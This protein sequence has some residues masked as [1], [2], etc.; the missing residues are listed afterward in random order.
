MASSRFRSHLAL[1]AGL[2]AASLALPARADESEGE[3]LFQE[4]RALMLAERFAEAC[5]K[6]EQSQ[7]LEPHGGTLL[8][9]AA[10]HE[11]VGRVATAWAEFHEALAAARA[12]GHAARQ[13]LAEERIAVL[14]PRLPWLTINVAADLAGEEVRLTFDGGEIGRIAWGKDMPIDPGEHLIVATAPGHVEVQRRIT[15]RESEHE[16]VELSGLAPG[17]PTPVS[18][19]PATP[20]D[21]PPAATPPRPLKRWVFEAG[22]F[23]AFLTGNMDPAGLDADPSTVAVRGGAGAG[24]TSCD[25]VRCS[26]TLGGRNSLAG[27]VSLFAGFAATDWL[28]VG[29]RIVAAPRLR[30]GAVFA[31][32]PSASMHMWGPLWVG[33]SLFVGNASQSERSGTIKPESGYSLVSADYFPM[34]AATGPAFGAGFEL[35]AE[36]LRTERGAL[37]IDTQPMFLA[38]SNGSAFMLPLG[39]SYRWR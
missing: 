3:R 14:E 35:R 24:T 33:A 8:N 13:K 39:V 30:G 7:R 16:I 15:A 17:A 6:L 20:T 22:I 23:A 12:E 27:G 25:T 4:G 19:L 21:P 29:G 28:H 10:C 37:A 5:P 18:E 31:T 34:T 9:V 2:L 26:Y 38:G 11:R 1:S 36:V 32:G